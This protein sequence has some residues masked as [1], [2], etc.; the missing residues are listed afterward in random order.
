MRKKYL[1]VGSILLTIVGGLAGCGNDSKMKEATEVPVV[2]AKTYIA[3]TGQMLD[4]I[5]Y[6]FKQNIKGN[7][8]LNDFEVELVIDTSQPMSEEKTES[9]ESATITGVKVDKN[10]VILDLEDVD[11][12]TLNDVIIDAKNKQ[13]STTKDAFQ[14]NT[15]TVDDFKKSTF[16][17]RAGTEL[18][19]WLYTPKDSQ[20]VPLVLWEHGGGEVL[21][22]SFEGS[23][24]SASQGATTWIENGKETAVLS[25]QYPENYSFGI[26]EIPEELAKME[27][28]N[29]AKYELIQQLIADEVVDP[30]RMYITGA[31]SGGGAALRF[32]MQYPDVF[33]GAIVT[34]AKD[35]IVPISKKYDLAYQLEDEDKLRI[36]DEQYQETFAAMTKELENANDISDVPIW[37][38]SAENDQ[39]CTSYTS[40]MMYDSL[41]KAGA[42][43]N[44]LTLYSDQEMEAAGVAPVFHGSWQLAYQDSEMIDWLFQQHK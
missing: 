37:F 36:S 23:N 32:I 7:V 1:Y 40:K 4:Q 24:L 10:K 3:P 8:T 34:S 2:T 27:E 33:A 43:K 44:I 42:T 29:T 16:K 21:A 11:Y 35:T 9:K 38:V 14:V 17:D 13:L 12:Q 25:V 39:V 18:T 30:Q 31:S 6:E 15:Q 41:S 26:S 20:K 28:Y 22:S 19:Y 5:V